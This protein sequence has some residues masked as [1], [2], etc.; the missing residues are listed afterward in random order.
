MNFIFKGASAEVE[1]VKGNEVKVT[2]DAAFNEK[3]SEKIIYVDYPN[4]TKVV[5]P[6]NRV[7]VDDGLI[8][9]VVKEIG[10]KIIKI[11]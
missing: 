10:E 9:L 11:D 7:F 6:G 2:T 3:C 4:I 1:M 5:K 8:S